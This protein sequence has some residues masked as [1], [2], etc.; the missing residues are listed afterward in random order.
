MSHLGVT[1]AIAFENAVKE[2]MEVGRDVF[3]VG[4]SGS[5][6]N[7]LRKLKLLE[8][9]PEGYLTSDRLSALRLAVAGLPTHG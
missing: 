1:A 9:L 3:M 2:A 6:E 7:R 5:T 4:V 8:R